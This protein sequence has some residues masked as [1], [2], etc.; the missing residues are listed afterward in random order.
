MTIT[1]NCAA[2][3]TASAGH[4]ATSHCK[5][6]LFWFVRT[7]NLH[8]T[9]GGGRSSRCDVRSLHSTTKLQNLSCDVVSWVKDRPT[10]S[11]AVRAFHTQRPKALADRPA[12]TRTKQ[13]STGVA[14]V[15]IANSAFH[16]SGAGKWVAGN[17]HVQWLIILDTIII[18]T[19]NIQ[20]ATKQR[21][22]CRR[23]LRVKV[24]VRLA[25]A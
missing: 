17:T 15:L 2:P 22:R 1:C 6:L 12:Y 13:G 18:I 20:L 3:P 24:I 7:C 14:K 10:G 11:K 19:F 23:T 8:A 25:G 16:P 5:P 21:S 4:Y 9:P